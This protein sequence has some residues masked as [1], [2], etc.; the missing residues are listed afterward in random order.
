ME[1]QEGIRGV[2]CEAACCREYEALDSDGARLTFLQR[3]R[4]T[5]VERLHQLQEKLTRLDYMIY[6]L[7]Q[8]QKSERAGG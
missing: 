7:E 8:G 5:M 3:H 1:N 4:R 2:G 6:Q